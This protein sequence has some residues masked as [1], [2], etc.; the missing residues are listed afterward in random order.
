MTLLQVCI[1]TSVH[2]TVYTAYHQSVGPYRHE[3]AATL[4][5]HTHIHKPAHR[6]QP[7]CYFAFMITYNGISRLTPRKTALSARRVT[8]C[9]LNRQPVIYYSLRHTGPVSTRLHSRWPVETELHAPVV[10]V[11]NIESMFIAGL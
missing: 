9:S 11:L 3:H 10:I 1:A 6:Q 4:H 5:T 2:E 8:C 7:G